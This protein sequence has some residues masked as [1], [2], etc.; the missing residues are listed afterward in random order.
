MAAAA[1][2][3]VSGRQQQQVAGGG[4]GVS[5]V[6][7]G[8]PET[9]GGPSYGWFAEQHGRRRPGWAT[10]LACPIPRPDRSESDRE[11]LLK[12][13]KNMQ[14]LPDDPQ[15]GEG[16]PLTDQARRKEQR[17]PVV[18][19]HEGRKKLKQASGRRTAR[20][21]DAAVP[22]PRSA[23]CGRSLPAP[24]VGSLVQQQG[25]VGLLCYNAV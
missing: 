2:P 5:A 19:P 13:K 6:A 24:P 25:I 15:M 12:G 10:T 14:Y 20:T 8:P 16:L 18:R 11:L 7:S 17:K 22:P 3:G 1:A 21:V 4:C 9:A 23:A